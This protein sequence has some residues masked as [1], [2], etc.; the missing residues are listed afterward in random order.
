[1]LPSLMKL[2]DVYPE[3]MVVAVHPRI[4]VEPD[5]RDGMP[6]LRGMRITADV[7]GWRMA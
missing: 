1:M 4:T 5:K 7:L 2:T 6:C 3:T